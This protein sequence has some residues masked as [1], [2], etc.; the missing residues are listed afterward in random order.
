MSEIASV[1]LQAPLDTFSGELGRSFEEYGF[2]VVRDHG[3]DQQ[4]INRAEELAQEFFALPEEVKRQYHRPG[5][6]GARGLTPFGVETAKGAS[7]R[8]LK[9]FYHVGR[10][11]PEGHRYTKF[12]PPNIWPD[13]LP[14]FRPVMQDLFLAF[15][16]TGK[17]ILSAIALYLGEAEDFFEDSVR[18]GN[19]VM[20]LLHYPPATEVAEEGA[21]RAAAHEDI[22]TIT[23]LLGAEE[24]GL[25]LLSRQGEWLPVAPPPG[26][27]AVNI[28]DMLQR[29]TAGKLRSTTHRVVNPVGEAAARSR[30]SM[31]FF[32]HFRPDFLIEPIYEGGEEPIT[33]QDYLMER[34]REIKLA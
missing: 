12:M 11:L 9:E 1:S 23:L 3:I 18:D 4:L 10:D 31:P 21:I 29:L 34:L 19:S 25:Q 33:A 13:E 6:G 2:A 30:Y 26:A 15:E 16:W 8:D 24:A 20:R 7:I 28:G 17:R 14:D 5:Q 22:N 32:L 27:L